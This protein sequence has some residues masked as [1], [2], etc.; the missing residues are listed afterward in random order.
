M[1]SRTESRQSVPGPSGH[2]RIIPTG[3]GLFGREKQVGYEAARKD[4]KKT[5]TED[6]RVNETFNVY[7][8]DELSARTLLNLY[9]LRALVGYEEQCPVTVTLWTGLPRWGGGRRFFVCP[10]LPRPRSR[11]P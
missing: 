10:L 3:K 1:A 11:W 7:C 6:I 8:T 2:I 4:E 5:E 9:V